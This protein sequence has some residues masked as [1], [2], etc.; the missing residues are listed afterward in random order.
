MK[1]L[2]VLLLAALPLYCSADNQ[3]GSSLEAFIPALRPRVSGPIQLSHFGPSD[4]EDKCAG[5]QL[6]E[7]VISEAIDPKVTLEEYKAALQEFLY[8]DAD[9]K[10]VEQFKQCFL[11]QSDET[12]GNV[13]LM[14]ESIYGSKYCRAF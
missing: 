8:S 14:M 10:A 7:D 12:L 13:Q 6:L 5:C 3:R 11:N 4:S 2:A 1:L 9:I